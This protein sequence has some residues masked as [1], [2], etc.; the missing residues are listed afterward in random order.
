MH[1]LIAMVAIITTMEMV[2]KVVYNYDCDEMMKPH[3]L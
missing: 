3:R 2:V 1:N